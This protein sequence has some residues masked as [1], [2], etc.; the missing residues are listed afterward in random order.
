MFSPLFSRI[1]PLCYI[2]LTAVLFFSYPVAHAYQPVFDAEEREN[3]TVYEKAAQ[4]TVVITAIDNGKTLT[5]TGVFISDTGLILTSRHVVGNATQVTLV[6]SNGKIVRGQTLQ[7]VAA[8]EST[9]A[10]AASGDLALIELIQPISSPYLLLGDSQ[11]VRVGQKVLAL[12]N[13]YG[14]ERTLTTGIISRIDPKRNL[15]QT[16]AVIN[17]GSSGGPLLDTRG[18]VIGINQSIFNPDGNRSNIGIGFA[19][20]VNTVKAFLSAIHPS[21]IQI[22]DQ[23]DAPIASTTTASSEAFDDRITTPISYKLPT[24]AHK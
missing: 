20:P 24:T 2:V 7:T 5:G 8:T 6:L 17:P 19:I 12:G 14:F 4:C 13:P 11:K 3:I 15:I 9:S 1:Q 10:Q 21:P 23:Q 22:A 18:Y 16:D